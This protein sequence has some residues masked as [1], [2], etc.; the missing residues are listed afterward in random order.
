MSSRANINLQLPAGTIL[1]VELVDELIGQVLPYIHKQ[2]NNKFIVVLNRDWMESTFFACLKI[3]LTTALAEKT[4]L[5]NASYMVTMGDAYMT[6][7]SPN[8][9]LAL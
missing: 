8:I 4:N 2:T 5:N 1:E 7:L 9:G 3:H 6:I